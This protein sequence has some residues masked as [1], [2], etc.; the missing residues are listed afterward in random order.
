[1]SEQDS[2]LEDKGGRQTKR[3]ENKESKDHKL[4]RIQKITASHP[5]NQTVPMGL[6]RKPES[7]ME[8]SKRRRDLAAIVAAVGQLKE[9]WQSGGSRGC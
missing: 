9:S 6:D 8:I 3:K 1:M 5:G 7:Q 2:V 4:K